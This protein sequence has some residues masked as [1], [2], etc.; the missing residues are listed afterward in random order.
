M[1][2]KSRHNECHM[3]DKCKEYDICPMVHVQKMFAGKWKLLIVWYLSYGV[4]RFSEIKAKLPSITQKMLTQ[5]LRELEEEG[6]VT[7]VV[8]PVV[9]PKVEYS[10]SKTGEQ[11][12]PIIEMMHVFGAN[13]LN[14]RKNK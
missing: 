9:P 14:E 11:L 8:Y 6:L 2:K 13:I 12:L 5:S 1:S 3:R 4:H 10:L 7:R